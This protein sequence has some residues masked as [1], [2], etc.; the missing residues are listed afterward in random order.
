MIYQLRGFLR[1]E[2]YLPI[3]PKRSAKH[4][5]FRNGKNCDPFALANDF[6]RHKPSSEPSLAPIL[7]R[8][9]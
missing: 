4:G 3:V 1:V 5:T 6:G 8:V 9:A 2:R 7:I